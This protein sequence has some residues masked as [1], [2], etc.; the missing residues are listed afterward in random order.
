M[1]ADFQKR[2]AAALTVLAYGEVDG[3]L[4]E[5]LADHQHEARVGHDQG[6]GLEGDDRG[7]VLDEGLDLGAVGV[8]VGHHVEVLAQGPGPI[9]AVGQYGEIAEIIV[10]DAQGIARLTCVDG[11]GAKSEGGVE[12]GQRAGGGEEFG[13]LG[14]H[15]WGTDGVNGRARMSADLEVSDSV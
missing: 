5:V 13:G 14:K 1:P 8:D 2:T 12:H 11:C 4:R 9:D 3:H 7:D 6:V 10:A 15:E